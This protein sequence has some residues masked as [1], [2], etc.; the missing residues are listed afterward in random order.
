MPPFEAD[1]VLFLTN[2]Q[3]PI[4]AISTSSP[5]ALHPNTKTPPEKLQ[6]ASLSSLQI[7]L[8]RNPLLK[9]Q[10]VL[11]RGKGKQTTRKR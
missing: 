6:V 5:K 8:P 9:Q 7:S 1:F 2:L 10:R 4:S 3:Q 11:L